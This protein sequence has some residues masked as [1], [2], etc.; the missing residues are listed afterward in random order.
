MQIDGHGAVVVG[1]ASGL[2]AATARRLAELGADVAILDR[3]GAGAADLA[4][5]I[6]GYSQA[7]NISEEEAVATGVTSAMARFGQA[8]RIAVC[9]V[10]VPHSAPILGPEGKVYTPVFRRVA[11]V[12][13]MG[14]YHLLTYAAQG[15][16][17]LPP[18]EDGARGVIVLTAH[19]AGDDPARGQAACAVAGAAL[20]ALC[21]T[22]AWELAPLGIRVVAL[23]PGVFKTATAEAI[24][25]AI[26]FPK[27][28]GQ[29]EEFARL[30][31]DIVQNGYVNGAVIPIDG[32]VK[33]S[34]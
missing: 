30:A 9:C 21:R 33:P 25:D 24:T 17:D 32:A 11:D 28:V 29:P 34:L 15:M 2:G 14:S 19:G 3:D 27:R 23:A 26:A 31:T 6:S 7:C 18:L 22:A 16:M 1:G 20:A 5:E 8:P 12:A 13:L 4:A 10:P